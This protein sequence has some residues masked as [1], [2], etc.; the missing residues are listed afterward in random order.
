MARKSI[1]LMG[2][3]IFRDQFPT[4]T[5]SVRVIRSTRKGDK[6]QEILGMWTPE[7]REPQVEE[8]RD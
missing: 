6:P 7:K 4:L 1:P 8:P 5:T 3:R 2:V